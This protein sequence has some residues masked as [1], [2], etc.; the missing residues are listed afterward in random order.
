MEGEVSRYIRNIEP[1]GIK[2]QK[3]EILERG[4]WRVVERNYRKN[5]KSI[6]IEIVRMGNFYTIQKYNFS[7]TSTHLHEIFTHRK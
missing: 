2:L 1:E 7:L 4:C 3:F 6:P 5:W